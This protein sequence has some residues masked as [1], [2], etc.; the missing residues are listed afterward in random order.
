MAARMYDNEPSPYRRIVISFI[1]ATIA[2]IAL[3]LYYTLPRATITLE[4]QPEKQVLET[5][6]FAGI[7]NNQGDLM[8]IILSAEEKT[9]KN[10]KARGTGTKEEYASGTVNLISTNSAPQ[11]LIAKTRLLSSDNIL[12]RTT[13]Q[14]TIPANGKITVDV[15]A[16]Q[17]GATSE[18]GPTKFT[19][20]GLNAT[21]RTKI[22]GESTEAMTRK[23]KAGT[24][25]LAS[26]IDD[27]RRQL[28]DEVTQKLLASLREKLPSD[29]RNLNVVYKTD[30]SDPQSSAKPGAQ[31]SEFTYTLTAKVTAIFYDAQS[32]R[33]IVLNKLNQKPDKDKEIINLD[34]QSASLTITEVASDNSRA[35][36]Q[37]KYL[38]EAAWQNLAQLINREELYGMTPEEVQKYFS[39]YPG[40]TN[41]EINLWPFWVKTVPQMFDHIEIMV[42]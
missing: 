42:K 7:E 5:E 10:Y 41:A 6:I 11:T 16:D 19:I 3:I 24:Q 27:A 26:D 2:V 23:E 34:E 21:L 25:I 33:Q 29:K 30:I 28:T 12:F 1:I 36:L 32:L 17:S 35:T 4:A 40:V 20:P 18:I 8:S 13:K 15:M 9:S 39:T 22:Y 31:A 37:A 14:I 38:G